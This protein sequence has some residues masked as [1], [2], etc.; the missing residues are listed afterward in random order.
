MSLIDIIVLA[1]GLILTG[2]SIFD[3]FFILKDR[4]KTP[5]KENEQRISRLE[6][7]VREIQRMLRNDNERIDEL[8][9]GNKVIIR[10]MSAL[11]SHG[12]DGNNTDEMKEARQELNEFLIN[13]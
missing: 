1:T 4:A 3:K 6:T 9:Q 5:H 12:I 11:L 7:D 10:S 2:V 8:E 13:K